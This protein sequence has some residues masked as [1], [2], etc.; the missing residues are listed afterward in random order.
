MKK[1][2]KCRIRKK[3]WGTRYLANRSVFAISKLFASVLHFFLSVQQITN[4]LKNQDE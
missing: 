1:I 3:K 4:Y 2:T